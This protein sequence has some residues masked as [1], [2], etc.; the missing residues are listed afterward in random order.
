MTVPAD[1][2]TQNEQQQQTIDST[3]VIPKDVI[4][5]LEQAS[6]KIAFEQARKYS[7][8]NQRIAEKDIPGLCSLFAEKR[9]SVEGNDDEGLLSRFHERLDQLKGKV[10]ANSEKERHYLE[11]LKHRQDFLQRLLQDAKLQADWMDLK[12]KRLI[13]EFYFEQPEQLDYGKS[14][15]NCLAMSRPDLPM[16]IDEEVYEERAFILADLNRAVYTKALQ[17][18]S[19]NRQ[20][21]KKSKSSLEFALRRQEMMETAIGQSGGSVE[22]ALQHGQKY[23]YGP[24]LSSP[25]I[26]CTQELWAMAESAMTAIAFNDLE[27][28]R[29]SAAMTCKQF[30]NEYNLLYG[31]TDQSVLIGILRAGLVMVKT[32]LCQGEENYNL[33]CPACHPELK[34]LANG[35][36]YAHHD[37]S[38]LVCGVSG[39]QMNEDNPPMVLPN[40]NV[41]SLKTLQ[42]AHCESVTCPRT[43]AVYSWDQVRKVYIT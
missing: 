12:L 35:L 20:S 33:D 43:G 22:A 9:G 21:L 31:L 2:P 8:A 38:I 7:R 1:Q 19:D 25:D 41:F 23:L 14:I 27:A 39:E 6:L 11:K 40:G 3:N 26:E 13:V 37:H 32:P 42:Q 30:I 5:A 15:L 24:W 16:W 28:V 10:L 4:V 17:W 36:P 29:E 34:Q 18:C